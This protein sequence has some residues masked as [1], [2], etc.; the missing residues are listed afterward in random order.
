MKK[1]L[2]SSPTLF[3]LAGAAAGCVSRAPTECE[4]DRRS[5]LYPSSYCDSEAAK[6]APPAALA[7]AATSPSTK[8]APVPVR[9]QPTVARVWIHDQLLEGGI[10]MEGTWAFIEV[11]PSRWARE[12]QGPLFVPSR[13]VGA[14][15]APRTHA[16]SSSRAFNPVKTDSD[17]APASARSAKG[18]L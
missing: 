12:G 5:G 8:P 7:A 4:L 14:R 13:T 2:L 3:L 16:P 9:E 18:A 1:T 10:L 6:K 15:E 11:E 17:E